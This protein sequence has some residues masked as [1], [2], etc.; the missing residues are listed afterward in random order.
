[1]SG[2]M[3]FQLHGLLLHKKNDIYDWLWILQLFIKNDDLDWK[4]TCFIVD[5]ATQEREVIK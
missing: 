2:T 5:D 1:M 4:T 3:E